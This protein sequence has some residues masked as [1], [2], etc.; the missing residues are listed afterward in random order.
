M[1]QSSTDRIVDR[2]SAELKPVRPLRPPVL[3]AGLWLAVS[4]AVIG[5]LVWR[6]GLRTD[7]G[8][9]FAEPGYRLSFVACLGTAGLGAVAA[10]LVSLPDRTALWALLP[11][12]ALLLWIAGAGLGCYAD[13]LRAGPGGIE[14]G[15]SFSC[16]GWI[17][18]ASL[19]LDGL[20]VF[21]IRHAAH[22]RPRLA[23][24]VGMMAAAALASA[25]LMLF[26]EIETTLMVLIW[27]GG[28]VAIMV[29]LASLGAPVFRRV[30]GA[31]GAT[32]R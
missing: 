5:A 30:A 13:W 31:T 3:G 17:V 11:L 20:L 8:Q 21:M 4:A 9:L 6:H 19:P 28:A 23:L 2:L 27:H 15:T 18:A 24:S 16:L 22:V 7:L 32:G 29:G 14:L 10:F 25:G 12:P 1:T 26:H